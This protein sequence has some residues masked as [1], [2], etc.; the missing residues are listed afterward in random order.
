MSRPA[1]FLASLLIVLPLAYLASFAKDKDPVSPPPKA[2]TVGEFALKVLK[3]A[4]GDSNL[5]ASL[6]A[7]E[8]VTRLQRAGL[9]LR[10]KPDDLLTDR[11]RSDF[12]LAVSQ[13]LLDK[14]FPPPAGFDSCGS[15]PKV[16]DCLACCAL[17]PGGDHHLCGRACGQA[18]ADQQHASPSG[19]G[20]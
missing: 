5:G 10:G 9:P 11:H 14:V 2:T 15:L 4:A 16:P 20:D 7:E 1:R 19:P 12:F 3:L 8:A 13:G 6:T 18:H 17:L